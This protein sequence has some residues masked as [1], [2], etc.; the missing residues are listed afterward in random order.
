MYFTDKS[1]VALFKTDCF[2]KAK[3]N[4]HHIQFMNSES[5]QQVITMLI[6]IFS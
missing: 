6:A 4:L 5:H 3:E 2:P 1:H